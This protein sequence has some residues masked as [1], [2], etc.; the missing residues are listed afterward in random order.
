MSEPRVLVISN[1]AIK[2]SNSN[3]LSILNALSAIPPSSIASFF[4]QDS[5]PDSGIA[6]T[7]FRLTDKE[8]LHSFF[9][10]RNQ[11]SILGDCL[12][13][14]SG[15]R[16]VQTGRK[17]ESFF[18]HLVRNFVWKHGRWNKRFLYTWI[19]AFSPTVIFFMN[20][21]SPFMFDLVDE[22]SLHFNIPVVLFSSEDEFWHAPQKGNLFDVILRNKLKKSTWRLVKRV[23]HVIA[24][25]DKLA[26]LYKNE[27]HLPVSTVMPSAVNV[28]A[29]SSSDSKGPLFYGGNL[30]PYRFEA[31]S[32]VSHALSFVDPKRKIEVY[33]NDVDDSVR[34]W[35]VSLPN[36]ILHEAVSRSELESLRSQASLL[37]H[38]ESFSRRAEPL[39]Q[40]AFSSKI[41]DCLS[42]GIPFFVFAPSYCGFS[43]YLASHLDAV[44][45]VDNKEV[46]TSALQKALYDENY[47]ASLVKNALA[48]AKKNHDVA[49]NAV[50]VKNILMEAHL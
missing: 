28:N 7:S 25:S 5:M 13:T 22:I 30:K 42:S 38:F 3:G 44:S 49:V 34:K 40:N 18:R 45:Y 36:V 14:S 26:D 50:L 12:E 29:L 24:F 35:L 46:L 43:P 2:R 15:S 10:G 32:E 27:F 8:K 39:I 11:G 6:S 1:T 9:S 48:L 41:S 47:R 21:R 17:N 4:I 31:L 33:S 37:L 16:D 19:S 20:G 23:S